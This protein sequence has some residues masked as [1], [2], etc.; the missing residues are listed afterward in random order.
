MSSISN[1]VVAVG[2]CAVVLLLLLWS[3]LFNRSAGAR[4]SATS[5]PSADE[6]DAPVRRPVIRGESAM[7]SHGAASAS[8]V[9]PS[10]PVA[11]GTGGAPSFNV[12]GIVSGTRAES[13]PRPSPGSFGYIDAGPI[14]PRDPKAKVVPW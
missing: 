11:T 7:R 10:P 2:L 5:S 14:Q 4:H 9:A 3:M 8:A 13:T 12:R 6:G 1:K